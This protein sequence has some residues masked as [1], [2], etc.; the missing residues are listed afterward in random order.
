MMMN[1]FL[2][3]L[4]IM[5]IAFFYSSVGH[6]GASGYLALMAIFGFEPQM[7]RASALILNL[8]VAGIAFYSYYKD[9]FFKWKIL[10]PFL[11]TSMPAAYLGARIHLDPGIYKIILGIFLLI[12]VVRML[13][14][15]GTGL[16]KIKEPPL[17]L[18]MSIGLVLGLLS[19]MIG[20]GG[21]IILTPILLLLR[22][23][24]IKEAAAASALFIFL[25]SS[26]GLI[27]VYQTGFQLEH[28]FVLWILGAFFAGFLGSYTGSR[29]LSTVNLQYVL[30]VVLLLASAKLFL[31]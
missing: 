28:G 2:F 10:L 14:L 20:I 8:F 4:C 12:A 24:N 23:A 3:I 11:I 15:K 21:G 26:T 7:M 18:A 16:E 31:F 13:F 25:N 29:K 5:L 30:A 6:G 19:G 27:G 9:G 1:E 17:I 22:Y